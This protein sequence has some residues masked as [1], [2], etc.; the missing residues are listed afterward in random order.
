MPT[1]Q[2]RK[3]LVSRCIRGRFQ[4]ALSFAK[5]VAGFTVAESVLLKESV[6]ARLKRAREAEAKLDAER[7][8]ESRP[9][10]PICTAE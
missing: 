9:S 8:R 2:L 6:D 10:L 5:P 1:S 7:D 3:R 4:V